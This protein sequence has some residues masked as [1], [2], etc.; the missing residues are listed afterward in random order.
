MESVNNVVTDFE[1]RV[2]QARQD[3]LGQ[4]TVTRL[5]SEIAIDDTLRRESA[6][7]MKLLLHSVAD[8]I[9]YDDEVLDRKIAVTRRSEYGYIPALVNILSAIYNWPITGNGNPA[10][11]EGFREDIVECLKSNNIDMDP[12]LLLDIKEAKGYH[13][14]VDDEANLVEGVE[15]DYEEYNFFMLTFADKAG[16]PVIDNK[17]TEARWNKLEDKALEKA[18]AELT[19]M[20]KAQALHDEALVA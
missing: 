20:K 7:T 17:L 1:A 12:D 4:L 13:S 9:G 18:N 8:E 5:T 3:K 14:F 10:E 6:R 11:V 16:L 19:E 15:P 2:A